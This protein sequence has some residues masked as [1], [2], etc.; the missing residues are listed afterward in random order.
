M[1]IRSQKPY[2]HFKGWT[3]AGKHTYK[4]TCTFTKWGWFLVSNKHSNAATLCVLLCIFISS[5]LG[6]T[7]VSKSVILS[8]FWFT[9]QVLGGYE[10]QN[11]S[12]PNWSHS[13]DRVF[14]DAIILCVTILIIAIILNYLFDGKSD[15]IY[16]L[17]GPCMCAHICISLAENNNKTNIHVCFLIL[18]IL[19]CKGNGITFGIEGE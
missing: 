18:Y 4:N 14:W 3:P 15:A 13:Q 11:H 16:F 19:W 10:I 7:A 12:F 2:S 1:L 6:C 9:I 8:G 17:H 5:N